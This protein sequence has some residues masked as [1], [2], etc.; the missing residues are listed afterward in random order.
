MK[1]K[2]YWAGR[3][4]GPWRHNLHRT[5]KI[6]TIL[7]FPLKIVA[8]REREKEGESERKREREAPSNREIGSE[9]YYQQEMTSVQIQQ[10]CTGKF[11]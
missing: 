8:R 9:K 11:F 4:G 3:R 7:L 6:N 5:H 10:K 1:W 2:F